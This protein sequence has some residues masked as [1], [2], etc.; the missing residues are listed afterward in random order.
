MELLDA[1][2]M[3]TVDLYNG[4]IKNEE[5]KIKE[6]TAARIAVYRS[7]L[8]HRYINKTILAELNSGLF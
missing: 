8:R 1:G 6:S 2:Y 3:I 7:T 5:E 4:G